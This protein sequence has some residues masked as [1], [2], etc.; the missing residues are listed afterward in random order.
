MKKTNFLIFVIIISILVSSLTTFVITNKNEDDY[1]KEFYMTETS[2]LVSPHGLRKAMSKG[3]ESFILVDLRSREEYIEEHVVGAVNIPAYKDR[4]HSDYGAVE[5]ISSSFREL[6]KN[7]PDKDI[8]VYC[9]STPCMTGRKV[10]R[11]LAEKDIYVKE[12]GI[13][14]NEWRYFWTTWNHP[15]EWETIDVM[16]YVVV[17]EEPGKYNG[18]GKDTSCP[19]EGEI[20]C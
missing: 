15:H 1:I 13:G 10:G 16:N 11:M 6:E 19:I 7:N 5:R 18:P 14:W 17:G 8:I 9:Y 20:G 12:L 2:V 3:D 4:D